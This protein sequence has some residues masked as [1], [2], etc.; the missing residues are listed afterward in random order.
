M[1]NS[2]SKNELEMDGLPGRLWVEIS[3]IKMNGSLWDQNQP[4]K[5]ETKI[6]IITDVI[7]VGERI[8]YLL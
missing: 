6:Q 5:M 4:N 2:H 1:Q 3:K 7:L 8:D